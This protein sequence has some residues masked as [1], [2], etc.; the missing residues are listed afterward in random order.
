[1]SIEFTD[2]TLGS[3]PFSLLPQIPAIV[4][5]WCAL[6]PLVFHL[7]TPR[8]DYITIG[9]VSLL[10]RI[11][12]PLLPRLGAL[13]GLAR[14]LN[15]GPKHLDYASFGAGGSSRTVWDVK[16]GSV[17]PAANGAA[18]VWISDYLR[19]RTKP[20]VVDM[21]EDDS[22]NLQNTIT[23]STTSDTSQARKE[24][25]GN[26]AGPRRYQTLHVYN[27]EFI[28]KSANQER[29]S[30]VSSRA[31]NICEYLFMTA[32]VIILCVLGAYGTA[33]VIFCTMVSQL[34]GRSITAIR[35]STYLENTELHDAGMLVAAHQNAVE[36]H[37][38]IGNR[39]IVD[40]LLNKP[41]VSFP[42]GPG[43]KLAGRWFE[44]A[45][46]LQLASMTYIAAQKGWDGV[47]LL[48]LITGYDVYRFLTRGHSLARAWLYAEG[49]DAKVATFRFSGR[50]PMLGAVELFK[51]RGREAW[52]DLILVPHPR[53]EAW[54]RVIRGQSDLGEGLDHGDRRWVEYMSKAALAAFGK[55]LDEFQTTGATT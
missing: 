26:N 1:M 21:P 13:L 29:V 52:M 38:Y 47:F 46:I 49:V 2:G 36:W 43:A 41:M 20:G 28:P 19:R 42:D 32:V 8:E 14:L 53:R 22:T 30:L 37:L 18:V 35:P 23:S 5:E 40:T 17:F 9:E 24:S 45:H 39:A 4:S 54:L 25:T 51:G 55:L 10:G 50:T 27:F 44:V 33:V 16:W 15:G 48:L 12:V 7:A 3:S 31:V 11:C 6:I 34:V